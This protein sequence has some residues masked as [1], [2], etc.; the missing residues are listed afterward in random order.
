MHP[1]LRVSALRPYSARI[2]SRVFAALAKLGA[3]VTTAAEAGATNDEAVAAARRAIADVL[4]IPFHAHRDHR[5]ELV[6]GLSLISRIRAEVPEHAHTPIVCPISDVGLAAAGLMAARVDESA[7][8]GV[9]LLHEDDI[10]KG[11]LA[12]RLGVFLSVST[13]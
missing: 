12:Q 8:A 11:D 3:E 5:G 4:L 10:A 2:R 6:D 7:F 13:E 1:K 9:L